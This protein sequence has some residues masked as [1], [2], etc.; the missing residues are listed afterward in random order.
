MKWLSWAQ[1]KCIYICL[2]GQDP[3]NGTSGGLVPVSRTGSARRWMRYRER[4]IIGRGERVKSSSAAIETRTPVRD[5]ESLTTASKEIQGVW[6]RDLEWG[7]RLV[8]TTLNS[9]YRL[10]FVGSD[11]F[12]ASGGWFDRKGAS[13][14]TIVVSGCS[15]GGSAINRRLVAAPGLHLEFGNGVVTTRIQKVI[16]TRGIASGVAH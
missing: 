13:P 11:T 7:D 12:V 10:I 16:V 2:V 8:V 9:I 1:L 14:L 5:L 3:K 6:R 15:W 4:R